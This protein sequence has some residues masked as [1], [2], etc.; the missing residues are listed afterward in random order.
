MTS[1]SEKYLAPHLSNILAS[2]DAG[3]DN[4]LWQIEN[5]FLQLMTYTASEPSDIVNPVSLIRPAI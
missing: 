2:N 5:N 3:P 4:R 1:Q